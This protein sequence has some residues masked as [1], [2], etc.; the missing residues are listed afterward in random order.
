MLTVAYLPPPPAPPSRPPRHKR[1]PA[2]PSLPSPLLADPTPT[3]PSGFTR[4]ATPCAYFFGGQEQA[5][6]EFSR[7]VVKGANVRDLLIAL[8]GIFA[9]AK[10][11]PCETMMIESLK[12]KDDG[13]YV[14]WGR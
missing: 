4:K 11:H 10:I 3:D 12:M 9:E 14:E 6:A 8:H 7:E 2:L 5:E 13:V 1:T